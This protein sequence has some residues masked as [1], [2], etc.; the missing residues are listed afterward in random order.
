MDV[1]DSRNNADDAGDI[2]R[3]VPFVLPRLRPM[4]ESHG[5]TLWL[6]RQAGADPQ[7]RSAPGKMD[8]RRPKVISAAAAASLLGVS[9]RRVTT[10]CSEGRIYGAYRVG[11]DWLI[12]VD[13]DGQP[14]TT[15][16]PR[17]HRG[18][19]LSPARP[20]R[21]LAAPPRDAEEDPLP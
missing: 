21:R 4:V 1:P 11:R 18:R 8:V 14:T 15:G 20:R 12:P 13:R 5:T 3:A 7:F 9:V 10:L 2:S 16:W 17:A 19:S 6:V